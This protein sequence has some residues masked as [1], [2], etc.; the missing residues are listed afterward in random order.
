MGGVRYRVGGVRYR[1]G[2][3]GYRVGGVRYR[4]GGAGYIVGGAGYRGYRVSVGL[5][6]TEYT[7][8]TTTPNVGVS[9]LRSLV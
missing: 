6:S 1:V 7:K 5:D 2:G 8:T 4:V 9:S 3:V